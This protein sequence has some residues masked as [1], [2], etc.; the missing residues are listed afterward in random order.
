GFCRSSPQLYN[1]SSNEFPVNLVSLLQTDARRAC[2]MYLSVWGAGAM[3]GAFGRRNAATLAASLILGL[4]MAG[5][6]VPAKKKVVENQP[7]PKVV[8]I[9]EPE[10]RGLA[11][12]EDKDRIDRLGDAWNKGLLEARTRGFARAIKDEGEL[13]KPAAGLARP[14]P[15]PGP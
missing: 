9:E 4:A 5:C 8:V 10:W 14:A 2:G 15:T 12:Q 6:T 13:L 11:S 7:P 3:I 1:R